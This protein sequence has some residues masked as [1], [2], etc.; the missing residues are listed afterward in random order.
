MAR[1]NGVE[2]GLEEGMV[3]GPQGKDMRNTRHARQDQPSAVSEATKCLN[4]DVCS[5]GTWCDSWRS[6]V[7]LS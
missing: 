6:R 2:V 7:S 1:L 4:S 5:V 3:G